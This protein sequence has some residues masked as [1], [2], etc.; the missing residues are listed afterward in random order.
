MDNW[1][2]SLCSKLPILPPWG[3][4]G[5][6]FLSLLF[7]SCGDELTVSPVPDCY[8]R[9]SC[10]ISTINAVMEQTHQAQLDGPGGYVRIY[11]PRK[12]NLSDVVGTG[13]LLLLHS[14]DPKP[15]YYAFDLACPYCYRTGGSGPERL[16][17]IQV[18]D[19]GTKAVCSKCDS[20][21]GAIFW[22]SPA[23]TAGPANKSND[24]LRQY[25]ATALGDQLVVTR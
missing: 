12:L 13:G 3:D 7:F 1:L 23:A 22:G 20:E 17:R 21:Y 8:V 19:D 16:Q 10:N 15:I 2:R 5:G 25:K 11:E 9:Y 24:I 18:S 4:R 14:L 6:L